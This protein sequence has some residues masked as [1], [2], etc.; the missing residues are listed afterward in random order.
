M[1]TIEKAL[2]T[3]IFYADDDEDDLLFFREALARIGKN[4]VMFELGDSMLHAIKNPPPSPSIIFLDLNMPFRSGYEILEDLRTSPVYDEIPIVILST[5][6]DPYS[7]TTT[8]ALGADLF[9]T[10]ATS[11]K[12]LVGSIEYV[13]SID[14]KTFKTTDDNF[15]VDI[16][17]IL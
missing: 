16:N 1:D 15:F 3:V 7:L 11:L 10:K 4:A 14:W 13:L 5:A 2:P 12:S 8:R 17:K 9:L 6:T